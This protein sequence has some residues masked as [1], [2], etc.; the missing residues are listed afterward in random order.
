MEVHHVKP[1]STI[2]DQIVIDPNDDLVQVCSNC[3]RMIHRK[4]DNVLS[5]EKLRSVH[6][7]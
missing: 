1:L 5:V 3:H 6:R 4:K 7:I 2:G